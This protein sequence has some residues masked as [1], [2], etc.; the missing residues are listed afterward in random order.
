MLNRLNGEGFASHVN[1]IDQKQEA[2][3]TLPDSA[4]PTLVYRASLT[5]PGHARP[6]K[7]RREY[8]AKIP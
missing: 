1:F 5:A 2:L 7:V 8:E 6:F 4:V 3:P